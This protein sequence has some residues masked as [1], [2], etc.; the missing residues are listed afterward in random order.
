MLKLV[1]RAFSEPRTPGL[2]KSS[3]DLLYAIGTKLAPALSSNKL[4]EPTFAMCAKGMDD[5]DPAVRTAFG[6]AAG[7]ILLNVSSTWNIH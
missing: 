7:Q 2:R 6:R 1:Q 5:T 3:G 4:F